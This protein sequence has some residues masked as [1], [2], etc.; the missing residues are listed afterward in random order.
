MCERRLQATLLRFFDFF[1]RDINDLPDVGLIAFG[2]NSI[3]VTA[4]R[5][6]ET[7]SLQSPFMRSLSPPRSFVYCSSLSLQTSLRYFKNKNTKM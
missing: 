5:Q 4:S 1:K 2:D 6:H 7:L 3:E